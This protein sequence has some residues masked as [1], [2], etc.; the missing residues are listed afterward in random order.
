MRNASTFRPFFCRSVHSSPPLA[1]SLRRGTLFRDFLL[2]KPAPTRKK[3]I[4]TTKRT[5]VTKKEFL[6]LTVGL[7]R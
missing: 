5:K 7:S 6:K 2:Q 3:S 4:F 1:L